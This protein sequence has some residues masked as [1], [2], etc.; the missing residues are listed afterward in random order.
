MART[1]VSGD[2]AAL[3]GLLTEDRLSSYTRSSG[4]ADG[5]FRLYEWNI[6]AASSVMA[7]TGVV[8]VITRNALDRE[9]HAWA[10][11]RPQRGQWLDAV[12]LDGQGRA[13]LAKARSRASRKGRRDEVHGRVVAELTLVSGG[14]WSSRGTTPRSGCRIST[15]PSRTA[16]PISAC[17]A[18]K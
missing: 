5:A 11:R 3:A 10:G 2:S 12:P 16:Q 4:S 18:T 15:E 6:K 14:T 13:D 17:G 7:L 9:L 1:L 8:E